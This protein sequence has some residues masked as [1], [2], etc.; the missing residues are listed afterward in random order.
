MKKT[1]FKSQEAFQREAQEVC[2]TLFSQYNN[3]D[4]TLTDY[5]VPINAEGYHFITQLLKPPYSSK[6]KE[7]ICKLLYE[8]IYKAELLSA[9]A[10]E[11]VFVAT[12]YLI[13]EYL[14]YGIQLPPEME[15]KNHIDKSLEKLYYIIEESIK[16]SNQESIIKLIDVVCSDDLMLSQAIYEALNLSGL[17]GKIFLENG[18]Q[19][20][21]VIELKEGYSFAL[22]PYKFFLKNGSWEEK[23]C[24][25]L[26]ADGFVESVSEIDQVLMAAHDK[27]QPL[28]LISQ[29]F[30]EEVVATLYTNFQK[31]KLNVIPLRLL[32]DINN[33]NVINDIGIVCGMDPISSLKG[34][35]LTFV[36]F[37]DLPVVEKISVTEKVTSI[38]N[39]STRNEVFSQIK[40]LLTKREHNKL[41]EDVQNILDNRIKSLSPNSVVIHLP[42]MSSIKLDAYRIKIDIAL[43]YC[44][45]ALNYGLINEYYFIEL[46]SQD[47]LRGNNKYVS[48]ISTIASNEFEKEYF[49]TIENIMYFSKNLQL[50]KSTPTTCFY[51]GMTLGTKLAFMILNSAGVIQKED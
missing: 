7:T 27:N 18:K 46:L 22:K 8:N 10:G 19:S 43:R 16:P 36:K 42:E 39:S 28:A 9:G 4:V 15:L 11:M 5:L 3:H 29:G 23:S 31:K 38:E 50:L 30:S 33:L 49:E 21:Y 25:V 34:E 47:K 17:E 40:Q 51:I 44:K 32:S 12:V 37:D 14:N 2:E 48:K 24:K 45:A 13:K 35:L 41:V 6:T 26:V 20:N 1:N